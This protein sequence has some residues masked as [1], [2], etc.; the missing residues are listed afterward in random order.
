MIPSLVATLCF[1]LSAVSGHRAAR[2]VGGSEANFWRLVVATLFLGMWAYGF[3]SGLQ[4]AAFPMFAASGLVGIGIGDVAM[5]QALPRL[6][7][8]L[9]TL[10]LQCLST[11]FAALIEWLWLGTRLTPA[12]LACDVVI[13]LGVSLALAPGPHLK[14]AHGALRRGLIFVTVAAAGNAL[15][16]VLSRKAYAVARS[17]GETIDGGT[18]AFQRILGGALVAGVFLLLARHK[19]VATHLIAPKV[20]AFSL[21]EKWRLAWPWVMA[22]GLFGMTIGVSFLQL[23]LRTT[24]TG[25]VLP[26]IAITPLAVIPLAWRLE[27][28]KPTVRAL[29]GGGIAVAGAAALAIVR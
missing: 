5:F 27:G 28:E 19:Q 22:N 16:M 7:S 21:K 17:A 18:A 13:L 20:S 29:V 12:E 2:L 23:A 8:R 26:I 6:G 9:T 1:A 11:P 24:P 3:G 4:G 15:G 25:I 14:L 10:L